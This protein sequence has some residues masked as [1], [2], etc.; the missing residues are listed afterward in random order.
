MS[1]PWQYRIRVSG[2]DRD[3]WFERATEH[4]WGADPGERNSALIE[5]PMEWVWNGQRRPAGST[6]YNVRVAN[7]EGC[8]HAEFF[9]NFSGAP[10]LFFG[11]DRSGFP[12]D[13]WGP[14]LFGGLQI[15]VEIVGHSWLADTPSG[16][17]SYRD[18]FVSGSRISS[19]TAEDSSIAERYAPELLV[20][21]PDPVPVERRAHR[22][23][24][25]EASSDDGAPIV[26]PSPSTECAHGIPFEDPK[27]DNGC[28]ECAK[29]LR[30]YLDGLRRVV[31]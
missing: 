8:D 13:R 21:F 18:V 22:D 27:K 9:G 11:N 15:E 30:M 16:I 7:V 24:D 29:E 23:D 14:P 10:G 20:E 5:W 12:E 6:W 19:E 17:Y 2:P 1:D 25:D 28:V 4:L 26:F 3:A 31:N